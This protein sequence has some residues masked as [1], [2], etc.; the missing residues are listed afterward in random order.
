MLNI[1]EQQTL[2]NSSMIVYSVYI[3]HMF[4]VYIRIAF[5]TPGYFSFFITAKKTVFF[6]KRLSRNSF[7]ETQKTLLPLTS[8]FKAFTSEKIRQERFLSKK[9]WKDSDMNTQN[10]RNNSVQ[11]Y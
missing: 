10:P 11:I 6:I 2:V 9:R 8:D 3:E 7:V 4:F 5:L 1:I